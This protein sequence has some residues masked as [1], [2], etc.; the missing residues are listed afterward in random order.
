M[1]KEKEYPI[2]AIETKMGTIKVE[3][4]ED[5]PLNTAKNFFR[6]LDEGFYE[7]TIFHRVIDNF[8]IQMGGLTPDMREKKAGLHSPIKNE[9]SSD[10]KND[11]GT[12][13]MARTQDIHSATCQF[14][15]N[16]NNNDF[17]NHKNNTA[18]GFGYAVFGKVVDGMDVVDAISKVRTCTI[19][20]Y[21]DVPAKPILIEKIK[22]LK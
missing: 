22:R 19:G 17:L 8:M 2:I 18:D 12:I 4:W 16:V 3:I 9:A 14:F 20:P 11:R 21:N 15:I 13:A 6:Y 7:G 1:D 10:L 5:K